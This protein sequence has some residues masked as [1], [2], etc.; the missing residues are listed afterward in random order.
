MSC[1]TPP[2]SNLPAVPTDRARFY[3]AC[4]K[5]ARALDIQIDQSLPDH[6]ILELLAGRVTPALAEAFREGLPP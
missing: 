1:T 5:L 6:E 3:V 2:P 4:F